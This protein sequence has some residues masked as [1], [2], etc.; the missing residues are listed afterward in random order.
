MCETLQFL[1]DMLKSTHACAAAC[2]CMLHQVIYSVFE[3]TGAIMEAASLN[4]L[5]E[6]H[7]RFGFSGNVLWIGNR[8]NKEQ[9]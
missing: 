3:K 8:T 2:S 4:C 5:A 9:N 7:R 6:G 1:R